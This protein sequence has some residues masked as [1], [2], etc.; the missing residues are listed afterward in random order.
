[1]AIPIPTMIPRTIKYPY[2]HRSSFMK[3]NNVIPA[4]KYVQFNGSQRL[5]LQSIKNNRSRQSSMKGRQTGNR[6]G[7][8]PLPHRRANRNPPNTTGI[9]LR[10]NRPGI[11]QSVFRMWLSGQPHGSTCTPPIRLYVFG[12]DGVFFIG[13]MPDRDS[14]PIYTANSDSSRILPSAY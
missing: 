13:G 7:A 5:F 12:S 11:C 9:P 1:M 4:D 10:I 6:Y 8:M 2:R 3:G 14:R